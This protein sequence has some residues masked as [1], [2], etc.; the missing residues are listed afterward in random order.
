MRVGHLLRM[1]EIYWPLGS[2]AWAIPL[3]MKLTVEEKITISAPAL[4]ARWRNSC[5]GSKSEG[6]LWRWKLK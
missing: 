5:E 2:R 3:V 4:T 1:W 6:V